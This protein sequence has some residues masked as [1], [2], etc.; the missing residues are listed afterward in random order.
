MY[1]ALRSRG[2]EHARFLRS[3]ADRLLNIACAPR[4]RLLQPA[5]CQAW[6]AGGLPLG[7]GRCGPS[8]ARVERLASGFSGCS[9]TPPVPHGPIRSRSG[10]RWTLPQDNDE[11][12][13]GKA[14]NR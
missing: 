8:G 3:V 14:G 11:D 6:L 7:Q 1:Q 9:L 5:P 13:H 2:H 4:R 10:Y 12:D